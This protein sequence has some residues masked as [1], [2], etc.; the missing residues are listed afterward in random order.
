MASVAEGLARAFD[1]VGN[2]ARRDEWIERA[3]SLVAAIAEDEDRKIIADQLA[4]LLG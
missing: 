1:A 2:G 3:Q 4:D